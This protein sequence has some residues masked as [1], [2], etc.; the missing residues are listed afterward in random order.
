MV[1]VW[2][3]SIISLVVLYP[4]TSLT[5]LFLMSLLYTNLRFWLA[6]IHANTQ[7]QTNVA[8]NE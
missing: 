4:P 1:R 5:D 3:D 8:S 7:T 2:L 6:G